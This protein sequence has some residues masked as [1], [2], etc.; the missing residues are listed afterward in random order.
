M[1]LQETFIMCL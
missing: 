1:Y